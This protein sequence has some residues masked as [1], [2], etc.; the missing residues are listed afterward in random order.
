MGAD[1]L[2]MTGDR[3]K[4]I[5]A[6]LAEMTVRLDHV[7][8]GMTRAE[9]QRERVYKEFRDI[10]ERIARIEE[11]QSHLASLEPTIHRSDDASKKSETIRSVRET[12]SDNH[13]GLVALGVSFLALLVSAVSG[14]LVDG[15]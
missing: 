1:E 4:G 15:R 9:G 11:R 6:R 2:D 8:L 3:E 7:D 5:E 13:R 12:S 10:A 14:F